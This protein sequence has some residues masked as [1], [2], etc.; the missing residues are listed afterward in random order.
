MNSIKRKSK[1]SNRHKRSISPDRDNM[2]AITSKVYQMF[3]PHLKK[4]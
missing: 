1:D 2:A 4:K 3:D